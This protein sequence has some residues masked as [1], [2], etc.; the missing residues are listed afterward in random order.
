[1]TRCSRPG[2][3]VD[4]PHLHV[5]ELETLRYWRDQEDATLDDLLARLRGER[6]ETEQMAAGR[7]FAKLMERGGPYTDAEDQDGWRFVFA[8]DF[9][10]EQPDGHEVEGELVFETPHGPIA[11]VGHA[12]MVTFMSVRDQ[13]LSERFDAERYTDSLQWRAYLLMFERY[14]F[15][16]D[17]FEGQYRGNVVTIREHHQ[18][19][20]YAYPDL[21]RDVERA[22][23]DLADIVARHMPERFAA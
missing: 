13:K 20:F 4:K 10:I 9:T 22:V 15:I 7:A 12:D 23:R 2:C 6:A 14:R 16:Y 11:L 19:T 1:M 5:S 17:V 21:R 18:L 8:G 3:A